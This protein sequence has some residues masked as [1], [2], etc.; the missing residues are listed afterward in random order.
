[1]ADKSPRRDGGQP[2]DD[3][4]ATMN[5]QLARFFRHADGLLR[6]WQSYGDKLRASIDAQVKG[7]SATVAAAVEDAG[8]NAAAR[9]DGQ[10]EKGVQD[11]LARLRR[12]LESLTRLAKQ[13][14]ERAHVAATTA[15]TGTSAD[16]APRPKR[17]RT[18]THHH[19]RA[20][21]GA[22]LLAITTANVMLAVLLVMSFRSCRDDK[23][24]HKA[25][26]PS[27]SVP[28]AVDA[29]PSRPDGPS[30][31]A[32]APSASAGDGGVAPRDISALCGALATEYDPDA[33]REFIAEGVATLCTEED[34][35]KVTET[36]MGHLSD[37][38]GDAAPT[39]KSDKKG[40][41]APKKAK[42]KKAG[43]GKKPS[44]KKRSS[45]KRSSG[46]KS[47]GGEAKKP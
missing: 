26:A 20:R 3:A 8:K 16:P 25:A 33:A 7:L 35:V 36:L 38:P 13:S 47:T 42:D 4:L 9:L 15:G 27:L 14:A 12:E 22:I 40:R 21:S 30:G 5:D 11:S 31:T 45:K 1:M 19:T 46:K 23:K 34:S 44:S 2:T 37:K 6:E 32:P 28:A 10:V 41:E 43:S 17:A 39:K 29:A 24:P 18:A